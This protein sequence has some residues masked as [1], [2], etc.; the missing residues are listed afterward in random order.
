[1]LAVAG[2][3]IPG[4]AEERHLNLENHY[5]LAVV[6]PP[7]DANWPSPSIPGSIEERHLNLCPMASYCLLEAASPL[8]KAERFPS[9][10]TPGLSDLA[11][12]LGHVASAPALTS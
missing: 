11:A 10:S 3:S 8:E 4:S 9:P 6:G 12:T 7:E 5:V 2:S 1:M